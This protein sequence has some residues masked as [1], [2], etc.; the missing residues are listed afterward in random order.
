MAEQLSIPRTQAREIEYCSP[1]QIASDDT[2]MHGAHHVRLPVPLAPPVAPVSAAEAY[3]S[4]VG[5][6]LAYS[7]QY[8]VG[9]SLF[10]C[11]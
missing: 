3:P 6:R 4:S 11:G 9:V 5:L 1:G 10:L 7:G 2:Q 8:F